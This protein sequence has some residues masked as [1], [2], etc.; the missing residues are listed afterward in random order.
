[1][2]PVQVTHVVVADC[3][4]ELHLERD[5]LTIAAFHDDVDLPAGVLGAQVTDLS[6]KGVCTHAHTLSDERLE[7]CA[8]PRAHRGGDPLAFAS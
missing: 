2:E 8:E 7:Q 1:L 4:G 3:G 6:A 5:H